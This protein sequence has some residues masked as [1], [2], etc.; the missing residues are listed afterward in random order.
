ML[1]SLSW[2]Y[3][4][5]LESRQ[6]DTARAAAL[7]DEAGWILDPSSG[8]RAKDGR[9]LALA[10]QTNLSSDARVQLGEL[11]A[12]QLDD[13]GFDISFEALEWGAFV[14]L[15][16]GQRFD[17]VVMSWTD[18][19]SGLEDFD[20]PLLNSH[21]DVPSQGYNFVSY[22]NPSVDG[23]WLDASTLPGCLPADRSVLYHQI[24]A[25]LHDELPYVWLFAPL[26]LTGADTQLIGI[27]PGPWGTW[28]NVESWYVAAQ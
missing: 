21:D 8:I 18:I 16:L 7:L 27:N 4:D 2:A 11:I 19:V 26:R 17:M 25:T 6:Y 3:N 13:L 28:Y 9:Q 24:Q 23:L 14:G 5:G 15:L 10:L 12:D 22:Y 1:P 20:L